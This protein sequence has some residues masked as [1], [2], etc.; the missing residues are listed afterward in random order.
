MGT[1]GGKQGRAKRVRRQFTDEF[2][3][4]A[5]RLVLD[6]GKTVAQV[7]RDLDLTASALGGWVKQARADR[8]GGKSGLTT[9]EKAELAALRKENRQLRVERDI[10]KKPRGLLRE[11]DDVKFAF[12]AAQKARGEFKVTEL[13]R[14]LRVSTSGFYAWCK[15]EPSTRSKKDEQ[16]KVLIKASFDESRKTYGSP[17]IHED[18]LE[19]GE[20][21]GRNR[22]I[23]L[24]QTEGLE[25]RARK[26]FKCTTI[27]DHDQPVAA[28]ILDRE[29]TA[30]APNQRWVGDTT[31]MLTVSGAKFYLA[32]I[33][34]LYSRFCV[35]WAVSAVNDRHL[36]MRALEAAIRRRCP[37]AG[38]LH[39]SD[40][41]STYAS[42]DYR[43]LLEAN[44]I[45]CSMSRR[46]NCLDNAA[47]ESWFS[48]VKF[49]LG[50]TF[51]SIGRA[52]EQLFDYIEVFYNQR[53]RHSTLDYVSPARA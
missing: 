4:G 50:E 30:D 11:G 15:R 9:E 5:V 24:M 35:G 42:E 22:V 29:F 13:C 3:A 7:A 34:D 6:E 51:E 26:R 2:K 20:K 18:L 16:L 21:I 25:A 37:S 41:G 10:Q 33:V 1:M 36:T 23:R 28:N 52:K 39:H 38:L 47:M 17:R 45:T 19:A 48:T 44:G 12:V 46:G 32:A 53:R 8:D 31:E 43:D 49:E 27:R 14:A 40:Q